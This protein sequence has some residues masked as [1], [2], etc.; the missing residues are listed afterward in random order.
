M[1]EAQAL[2]EARRR[3]GS[4]GAV[5]M[6]PAPVNGGDGRRGRLARYRYVVGNGG[7]GKHCSIQGQADSWRAAFDDAR[8]VA[9]A[10]E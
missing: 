9:R 1:T 3:W 8:P 10:T 2:A 4:G 6:R 7:L 5:R